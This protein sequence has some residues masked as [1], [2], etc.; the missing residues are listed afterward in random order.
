MKGITTYMKS[1]H[2]FIV[3]AIIFFPVTILLSPLIVILLDI[4]KMLH[5]IQSQSE[6]S[7]IFTRQNNNTQGNVTTLNKMT[8]LFED[9][10]LTQKAKVKKKVN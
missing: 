3:L 1:K 10:I 5:I 8:E 7:L 6:Q 4:K 2:L 9:L